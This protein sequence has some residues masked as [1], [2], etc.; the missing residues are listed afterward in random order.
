MQVLASLVGQSGSRLVTV[1]RQIVVRLRPHKAVSSRRAAASRNFTEVVAVSF[2]A[3]RRNVLGM[4][5]RDG[6]R[7]SIPTAESRG[8]NRLAA[9]L[10][11]GPLARDAD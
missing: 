5:R 10:A 7:G 9:A 6:L 1:G 11:C 8:Q 2:H 4:G 3:G